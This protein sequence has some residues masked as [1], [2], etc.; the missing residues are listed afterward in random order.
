MKKLSQAV[1]MGKFSQ[2]TK[3]R[4]L[5]PKAQKGI[6]KKKMMKVDQYQ[7]IIKAHSLSLQ[8]DKLKLKM[9]MEPPV[10]TLLKHCSVKHHH[11]RTLLLHLKN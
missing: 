6:F 10:L 1:L 2:S 9:H 8:K 3:Q 11:P 4:G 5:F 7:R